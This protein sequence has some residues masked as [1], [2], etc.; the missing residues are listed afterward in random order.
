MAKFQLP[1][2]L[3]PGYD[4]FTIQR[5]AN[6]LLGLGLLE[7]ALWLL[8]CLTNFYGDHR[9]L[10]LAVSA[11]LP[12]ADAHH[13]LAHSVAAP[14]GTFFTG[15]LQGTLLYHPASLLDY[16]LL[17]VIG[18][19]TF[20][21]ALYFAG[22]GVYLHRALRHLPAGSEFTPVASQAMSRLGLA[23]GLVFVLKMGLAI[24]ASEL[25]LLRTH[26]QFRLAT[27]QATGGLAYCV[28]GLLLVIC[29]EFFRRGRQLQRD[30][31]LTI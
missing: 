10:L 13:L 31:E 3:Q 18:D 9:G 25:L 5:T 21:D 28:F 4:P 14:G 17:F 20:L 30:S 26:Q 2:H 12:F 23:T 27:P 16:P 8:Y 15:G 1:A 7:L 29:G 24:A 6:V 19:L 22:L 11:T